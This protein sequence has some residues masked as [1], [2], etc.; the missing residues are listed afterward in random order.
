MQPTISRDVKEAEVKIRLGCAT[1]DIIIM[2]QSIISK[3]VILSNKFWKF[4]QSSVSVIWKNES[5]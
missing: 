3:F 2:E 4:S 1:Q 5:R